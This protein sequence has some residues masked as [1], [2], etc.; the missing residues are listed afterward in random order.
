[1]VTLLLRSHCCQDLVVLKIPLL[2]RPTSLHQHIAVTPH[3][4][5]HAIAVK[6]PFHYP[7][8]RIQWSSYSGS[9]KEMN[10]LEFEPTLIPTIF[11]TFP[12][13]SIQEEHLCL[14]NFFC[15]TS[16]LGETHCCHYPTVIE[17]TILS[18]SHFITL[19]SSCS[20]CCHDS[21]VIEIPISSQ[22]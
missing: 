7:K 21:I 6:I 19:L 5:H 3:C 12:G 18:R 2:S 15:M 4:C 1:M 11:P 13:L 20:H 8:S 14:Y 16:R 10:W 22:Y 9:N 17:T